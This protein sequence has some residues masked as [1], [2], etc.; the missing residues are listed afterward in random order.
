V[1]SKEALLSDIDREYRALTSARRHSPARYLESGVWGDEWNVRDL[2][3][4]L[5]EWHQL[6]LGWFE[7]GQQG[8]VPAIPAR[9][10]AYRELP[11]LNRDIQQ[12]YGNHDPVDMR[13]QLDASHQQVFAL[14]DRLTQAQLLR[15]GHFAWTRKNALVTYLGANTSSHYRFA[16]KVLR[17]W[18][19]KTEF[20]PLP[21]R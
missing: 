11:R 13:R 2:V 16:I 1:R 4:H 3:A 15:P 18:L 19:R 8:M 12:R 5:F 17:R 20:S 9:G 6:F 10:F 7:T 14:A 21:L